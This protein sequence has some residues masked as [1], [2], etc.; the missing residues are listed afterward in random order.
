VCAIMSCV[1]YWALG[2]EGGLAGGGSDKTKTVSGYTPAQSKL[3]TNQR[4]K[5]GKIK[6]RGDALVQ[7]ISNTADKMVVLKRPFF[8]TDSFSSVEEAE[9]A[10]VSLE[11]ALADASGLVFDCDG[12]L[13][14]TMPLYYKSWERTCNDVG[15]TLSLERFYSFAGMPV[16]DI[17]QLLIDEQKPP[18]MNDT[19]TT[20][21]TTTLTAEYCETIK[22]HHAKQVEDGCGKAEAIDVMVEIVNKYHNKIPMAVASSGW[23]DH[24]L[25][26]LER[27]GILDKFDAI[28]TADDPEVSKGKPAPDIFLV[29]AKRIGISPSKCVG[30][31]DADLGMQA[32]DAAGFMHGKSYVP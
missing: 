19:N 28:V 16:P 20:T 31:E 25:E 8:A 6:H 26:G 4:I 32:L 9:E 22:R 10:H 7:H 2:D 1:L 18:T 11:T 23:R 13:L 27:I 12:T 14:D 3:S 29:A 17:F 30:F 15:L 24:V 21:D 5:N